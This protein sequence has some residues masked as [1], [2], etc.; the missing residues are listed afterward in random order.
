MNEGKSEFFFFSFISR[1][2]QSKMSFFISILTDR[3]LNAVMQFEWN[4]LVRVKIYIRIIS[5]ARC[6]VIKRFRATV[7]MVNFPL[8]EFF[9]FLTQ[10]QCYFVFFHCEGVGDTGDHWRV[11]CSGDHWLRDYPIK[12][13]HIDTDSYLSVSGRTF[14]RPISGQMEIMGTTNA[15]QATEWKAVEGLFIHPS[16]GTDQNIHTEL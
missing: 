2:R 3:S 1:E 16:S 5:K 14:G 8:I 13:R 4:T 7:K 6:R 11:E 12:L 10:C 15:L 9:S